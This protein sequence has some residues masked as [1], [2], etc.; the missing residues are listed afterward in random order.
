[1][2]FVPLWIVMCLSLVSVLYTIIFAGILI[3]T[4]EVNQRQ[5]RTS[6]NVAIG[7]TLLVIPI[8]VFQV[9]R[10]TPSLEILF[11]SYSIDKVRLQVLL[12]N[13]LDEDIEMSY[14]EVAAPLLISFTSL[15]VMSF[16]S[17]GGN[18]CKYLF[19]R[20][21]HVALQKTITR[22]V[23]FGSQGGSDYGKIFVSS[24]QAFVRFFKSTR[25]QPTIRRSISAIREQIILPSLQ[26]LVT[27]QYYEIQKAVAI[28]RVKVKRIK[29]RK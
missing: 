3:R 25:T 14:F 18:K 29:K 2:V 8:L 24:Y 13:K 16:N 15:I 7:Y 27:T 10:T 23:F 21:K 5:R 9:S 20:V 11:R 28:R 26:K 6:F 17:K 1:M 22:I 4:P 12:T 19:A